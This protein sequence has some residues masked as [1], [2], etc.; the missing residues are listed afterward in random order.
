MCPPTY[1]AISY[2]INPWMSLKRPVHVQRARLQWEAL[3]RL[4][5]QRLRAKV[6]LLAPHPEVPDLTFTA[7]AGL[8]CGRT[9]IA[10]HFRYPERQGEEP[11]VG[12]WA[13]LAGY[14]VARLEPRFHFEGE[15]D[16]LWVGSTLLVGFRFRSDAAAHEPLSRLVRAEVLALEL[17]D[18]R[19]YHLDTCF[20]PLSAHTALWYPPA[21]DRYGQRVLQRLI[22]DLIAVSERDALRFACNAIVLGRH[23]ILQTG[24]SERL[25]RQLQQR[26]FSPHP[27]ELSEF[28][29]AGG[30]AKCL[31]LHL[32]SHA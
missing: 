7:N 19:F 12:R 11:I 14:R 1:Y 31:V 26:R 3:Y 24:C 10:S 15:G 25:R 17:A 4:L 9:F 22:P 8:V 18:K 28:H 23:V 30:S 6:Q 2:E 21:F 13:R 5:T 16:A 20:S 32:S 27:V 29:K